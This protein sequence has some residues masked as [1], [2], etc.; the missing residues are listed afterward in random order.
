MGDFLYKASLAVAPPLFSAIIRTLFL[1]CRTEVFGNE[2]RQRCRAAGPY[3]VAFW[4]YGTYY[5]ILQDQDEAMVGMVSNSRDGEYMA[6]FLERN[7]FTTVRGS[8]GRDKGGLKALLKMVLEVKQGK[9]GVIVADGS[10]GPVRVVQPGAIILAGRTGAPVLPMAWAANRYHA[11]GTW[12]RSILP[13]P[14]ARIALGY[15]EPLYV[16]PGIRGKALEQ[17]RLEL[18]KRL[19]DLYTGLWQ[20]FGRKGH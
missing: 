12:D 17:K 18:E 19:N 14:F 11:F 1:T 20:R 2:H 5:N 9:V 10:Q 16:E 15:G 4:H 8:R 3:I 6:R 13:L 7:G